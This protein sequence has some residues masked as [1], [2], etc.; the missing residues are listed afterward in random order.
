M[1]QPHN[2]IKKSC[3]LLEY[4]LNAYALQQIT[5]FSAFPQNEPDWSDWNLAL[6]S[7]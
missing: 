1:I 7:V 6:K 3:M 4:I 5:D 2:A